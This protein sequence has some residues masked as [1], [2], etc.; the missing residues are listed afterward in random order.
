ME[1]R[2][3]GIIIG[4]KKFG[5]R[6]VI[7]EIMTRAH[8]R[9]LGV[10]RSGRSKTMLPILQTGNGVEA[11][12]WARLEDHLGTYSIEGSKLRAGTFLAS[13]QALSGIT[14][15]A[16]LLRLL[17]ER[18]PHPDLY[19][20]LVL[21]ADHLDDR[22]IAAPLM[23]LFELAMLSELGFGIDL[24]RCAATGATEDLIYVSPKSGRAVSREAGEP[25]KARLLPLPS[26]L[27]G[28]VLE[29]H[30]PV[31]DIA[32]GFALTGY[33]LERDVFGPRGITMAD[34]RRA[35]MAAA[36]VS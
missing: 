11:V 22:Q 29:A 33:F 4:V 7:L 3:E 6:S 36:I 18:D 28:A 16:Y 12:W 26:F 19:D 13:R 31:E 35:F 9:H 1:W 20:T 25:Y 21:V 14:H 15:L 5:E 23:V 2:D 27:K 8:G 17:P 24:S 30:P 32:A 34:A 10:V